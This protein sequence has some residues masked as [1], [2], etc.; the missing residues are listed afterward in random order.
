VWRRSM[1][2][3]HRSCG[4][5]RRASAHRARGFHLRAGRLHAGRFHRAARHD[6]RPR[7]WLDPTGPAVHDVVRKTVG[8]LG[9][10][11]HQSFETQMDHMR[12]QS[13]SSSNRSSRASSKGWIVNTVLVIASLAVGLVIVELTLRLVIKPRAVLTRQQLAGQG[14]TDADQAWERHPDLGWIIKANATFRHASQFGEFDTEIRTDALGIRVP[15]TLAKSRSPARRSILVIGDSVTAAYEVPYAETFVAKLET[16]LL[17]AGQD[18]RVFNAGIR[19]YSTEQSYKRM[20]ALLDHG[21]LGVTDV[22]YLFSLNDPFENLNLHFPKRQMSKPG[23]YLDNEGHL[24][25]RTLDYSVGIFDSEALF[26]E[27][28]GSI[29]TLPVVGRPLP[30]PRM[31]QLRVRYKEAM[32]FLDSL[33][34]VELAKIARD[35]FLLPKDVESVR[36]Q[37]SY[38]KAEYIADSY[39][40]YMPG[41]I[42]ITWEPGSYPLRLLEEIIRVMKTEADRRGV[43]FW[44]ALPLTAAHSSIGFFKEISAKHG[45][46]LIDP[47]SDGYRERWAAKCGGSVVFKFDGHYSACGHSGQARAIAAAFGVSDGSL[48]TIGK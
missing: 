47:V 35:S 42:D 23:A 38:I 9:T 29:G 37:Y 5:R 24:K 40:G 43:R 8:I 27:P 11:Q 26:V 36:A 25:F 3:E 21:N 6:I 31:I 19:G 20:R 4:L 10:L 2:V 18:V 30:S 15:P 16:A 32:G 13:Q 12:F 14:V 44:L 48:E 22:V 28:G 41:F 34:L 1:S 45:I 17:A 33:Y 39:G 7:N 46:A